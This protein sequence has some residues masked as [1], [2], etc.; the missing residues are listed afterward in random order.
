MMMAKMAVVTM[1]SASV[2][3][4]SV[5]AGERR[6]GL[7]LSSVSMGSIL[8]GREKGV[9]PE[10]GALVPRHIDADSRELRGADVVVAVRDSRR[11]WSDHDPDRRIRQQAVRVAV[12]Q[13]L[14]IPLGHVAVGVVG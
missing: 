10:A 3:P 1:I 14:R 6:M 11:A 5:W 13:H 12:D 8:G 9:A 4:R 7:L 2:N